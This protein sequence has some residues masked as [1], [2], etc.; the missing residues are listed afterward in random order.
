MLQTLQMLEDVVTSEANAE[1]AFA[2]L[3]VRSRLLRQQPWTLLSLCCKLCRKRGKWFAGVA[4]REAS[5]EH[6]SGDQRL[7]PCQGACR[8]R[9]SSGDVTVGV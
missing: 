1:H 2:S 9:R 4:A 7:F 5:A 3:S 8:A 6:A